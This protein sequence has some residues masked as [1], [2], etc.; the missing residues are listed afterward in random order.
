M[1]IKL[2]CGLGAASKKSG[3]KKTTLCMKLQEP[4]TRFYCSDF[5]RL[6]AAGVLKEKSFEAYF[7]N[8]AEMLEEGTP[9][10]R[11]GGW[12]ELE[13]M[14]GIPRSTYREKQI[15]QDIHGNLREWKLVEL[16]SLARAH[17]VTKAEIQ[18]YINRAW[19]ARLAQK[20]GRKS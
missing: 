10:E 17:L 18:E 14:T 6:W 2:N 4:E 20:G 11:A 3:I 12:V 9:L 16:Q 7:P 8:A 13:K 1:T 15:M 5:G 19:K